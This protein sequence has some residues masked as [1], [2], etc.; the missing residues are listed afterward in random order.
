MLTSETDSG[1]RGDAEAGLACASVPEANLSPGLSIL[2]PVY[3][4]VDRVEQA[5]HETLAVMLP[6]AFEIV[7]VDDGSTDGTT[8]LLRSGAWPQNVR[9]HFHA[10][11]RGKGAAVIFLSDA[12]S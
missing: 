10:R 1:F 3:N 7:V 8:E 12:N 5:L 6:C 9:V 11:N 4:E 2:M